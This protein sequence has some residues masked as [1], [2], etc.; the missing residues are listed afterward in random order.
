MA[1]QKLERRSGLN[2]TDQVKRIMHESAQEIDAQARP[3]DGRGM[4]G[5]AGKKGVDKRGHSKAT[6]YISLERQKLV[7][8]MAEVEDVRQSDIV[9]AAVQLIYNLW[10]SKTIDLEA[11]KVPTRSLKNTFELDVPDDLNVFLE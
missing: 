6:Y 9:E 2:V 4:P 10:Q 7:R 8:G 5:H 3:T 1:K 11:M